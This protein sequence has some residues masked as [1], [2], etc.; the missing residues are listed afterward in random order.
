MAPATILQWFSLDSVG[1]WAAVAAV[2][3]PGLMAAMAAMAVM[4]VSAVVEVVE[5]I[6]VGGLPEPAA[7]AVSAEAEVV[8]AQGRKGM[9]LAA[10]AATA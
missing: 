4:A 10:Q 8:V 6:V 1:D 7:E 9:V 3:A 2:V 5:A